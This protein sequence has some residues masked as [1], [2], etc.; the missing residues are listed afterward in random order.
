MIWYIGRYY[1]RE[2]GEERN[3]EEKNGKFLHFSRVMSV[4]GVKL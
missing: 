1:E 4:M 2:K 3:G